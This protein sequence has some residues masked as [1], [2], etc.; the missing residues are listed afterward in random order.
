MRGGTAIPGNP[1]F[2]VSV[3]ARASDAAAVWSPTRVPVGTYKYLWDL[4]SDL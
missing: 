4:L 3:T 2:R 1:D